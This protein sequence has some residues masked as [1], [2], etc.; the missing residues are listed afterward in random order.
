MYI[1]WT[2]VVPHKLSIARHDGILIISLGFCLISFGSDAARR[3]AHEE[4]N[5]CAS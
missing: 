1:V 5:R 2:L 4:Y 3:R